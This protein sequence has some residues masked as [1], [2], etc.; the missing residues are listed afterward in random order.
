MPK[1]KAIYKAVLRDIYFHK[2]RSFITFF[3]LFLVIA[4]PIAMFSTSPSIENSIETNYEEY[5]LAQLDL[6][7]GPVHEDLTDNISD[8][9]LDTIGTSPERIQA[10]LNTNTKLNHE[11]TWY[12]VHTLGVDP[13]KSYD[14]NEVEVIEGHFA[15]KEGEIAILDTFASHLNVS[16]GDSLT[17]NL[18]EKNATFSIVGLVK[19]INYLSY[20]LIQEGAVYL[21]EADLR[22]LMGYPENYYNE[23]VI[24][25]S[26]NTTDDEIEESSID[27]RDFLED[28]HIPVYLVWHTRVVSYSAVLSDA[29]SLTSSYLATSAILIIIIVG[30]VIFIITKRYAIEQRKQTG[31]LYSYGFSSKTIMLAFLLRTFILSIFAIIIGSVAGWNLLKLLSSFLGNLWGLM[32]VTAILTAGVLIEVIVST[33]V[34]SLLFTFLAARENVSLTPYEAIRGK[35]KEFSQKLNFSSMLR[36]PMQL[37]VPMRNVSRSKMRSI[38][39]VL[40]FSGSIMLSFSLINTQTCLSA[41]QEDYF[42]KLTWDVQSVFNTPDYSDSIYEELKENEAIVTSEPFLKLNVQFF[43]QVEQMTNLRGF[44]SNSTLNEIDLQ[45]GTGFSEDIK[46]EVILSQYSADNLGYTVGDNCSFW[47]FDRQINVTIVGLSRTMDMP[48]AMYIQLETLEDIFGFMPINGMLV[49]VQDDELDDYMDDLNENPDVQ[50]AIKKAKFVVQIRQVIA[51]QTVIVNIMVVLGLIVSFLS[52]FSTTLIIVIERE[53]EY[54]L[55]RVFG[56]STWQILTQIFLEL[57]FLVVIALGLGYLSGNYLSIYWKNL[58]ARNFFSVDTYF[59]WTDY[60]LL[61]IFALGG[62]LFSLFPEYRSLQSQCL[63]EG[64]KEE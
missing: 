33:F 56:F 21:N 36:F 32:D 5:H 31:M 57:M 54:A 62:S 13:N 63:A 60:V 50:F 29:L 14:I 6:F 59:I 46:N 35:A 37:K 22:D 9:I 2:G 11:D 30:I 12:S 1:L 38:L 42:S 4:F 53:R 64:I 17:F 44:L 15:M 26:E 49:D 10:R 23:V 16:L 52:I 28:N 58:V 39:T 40:A 27:V 20:E 8:T 25:F 41:T 18:N 45:E 47:L 24:Y 55:Q 61:F 43:E 3:A 51:S 48:I 34:V 19:A 7:L